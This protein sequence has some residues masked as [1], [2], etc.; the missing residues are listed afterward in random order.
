V[1]LA[2]IVKTVLRFLILLWRKIMDGN[3]TKNSCRFANP[4]FNVCRH[5]DKQEAGTGLRNES[6]TG[7]HQNCERYAMLCKILESME[8]K[9]MVPPSGYQRFCTVS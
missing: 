1:K 6:C 2:R 4:P 7:D 5:F 9:K 3:K 8:K